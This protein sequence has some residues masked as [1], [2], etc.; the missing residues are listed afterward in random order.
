MQRLLL[1]TN[2]YGGL[3]R[4]REIA[5]EVRDRLDATGWLV[6]IRETTG[7]GAAAALAREACLD[8][9]PMAGW[10]QSAGTARCTR[11]S[12]APVG[13]ATDLPT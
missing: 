8:S 11:W 12:E 4:G 10:A 9:Y 3:G 13:Q 6:D 5:R 1:I 2:P 7:P